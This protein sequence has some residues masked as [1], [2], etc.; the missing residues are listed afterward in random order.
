MKSILFILL[1]VCT[2]FSF[3]ADFR[4]NN[5]TGVSIYYIYISKSTDEYWGDDMLGESEIL[6]NGSSKTYDLNSHDTWDIMLVDENENTYS[7]STTVHPSG[8]VWNVTPE[9]MD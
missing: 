7:L 4:I 9:S 1:I 2:A 3:A 5:Q 8:F 6:S